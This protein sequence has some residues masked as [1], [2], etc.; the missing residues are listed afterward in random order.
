MR[1]LFGLEG[2]PDADDAPAGNEA[3]VHPLPRRISGS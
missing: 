3:E 2:A 1:E